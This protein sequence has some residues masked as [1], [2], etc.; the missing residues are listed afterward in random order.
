MPPRFGPDDNGNARSSDAADAMSLLSTDFGKA[1]RATAG[2]VRAFVL[3]DIASVYGA[4]GFVFAA[5][6]G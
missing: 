6:A 1:E 2:G 3:A 5:Q 4:F